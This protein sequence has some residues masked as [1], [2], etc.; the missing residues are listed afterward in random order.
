[1]RGKS[2]GTFRNH[3]ISQLGRFRT[4]PIYNMATGKRVD[5]EAGPGQYTVMEYNKKTGEFDCIVKEIPKNNPENSFEKILKWAEE[6]EK[7]KL[8][9]V[10]RD[11]LEP[12]CFKTNT[13]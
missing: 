12:R 9:K 6:K 1:M 8:A 3:P 13:F 10:S 11:S 4:M 5:I 2:I 7:K